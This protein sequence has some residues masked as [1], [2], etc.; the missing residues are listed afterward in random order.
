MKRMIYICLVF[1]IS[2]FYLFANNNSYE[3]L[4]TISWHRDYNKALEI[5]SEIGD[6]R[7]EAAR[8][9]NLGQTYLFQ[10]KARK[11]ISYFEQA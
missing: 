6:K 2:G 7:N 8:L 3:E 4:G 10:G 9:G 1:V 11:A 5:A